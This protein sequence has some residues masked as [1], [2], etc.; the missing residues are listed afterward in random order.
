MPDVDIKST[1]LVSL[2]DKHCQQHLEA[3][4]QLHSGQRFSW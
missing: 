2:N 1:L 3:L 4:D